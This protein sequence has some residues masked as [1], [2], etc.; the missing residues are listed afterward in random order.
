MIQHSESIASIAPALFKVQSQVSAVA[1]TKTNDFHKYKYADLQQFVNTTK[2]LLIENGLMLIESVIS[3]SEIGIGRMLAT[4]EIMLLHT[5]GEWFKINCSGEGSDIF[6]TDKVGDK[7]LYKATTGARKYAIGLLLNIATTD[8]PE[9]MSAEKKRGTKADTANGS[10]LG[11]Q[12]NVFI[13]SVS[14]EASG[15]KGGKKWRR[16]AIEIGDEVYYTF[17][18]EYAR[19]AKKFAEDGTAVAFESK[20]SERGDSLDLMSL[21]EMPSDGGSIVDELK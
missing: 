5:S 3:A 7:G 11:Y 12:E 17:D 14:L 10:P 18:E 9:K 8:D 15:E 1:R 4:L 20:Q 16:F 2:P 19:K 6:K 21:V 13:E